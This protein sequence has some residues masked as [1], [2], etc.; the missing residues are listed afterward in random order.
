VTGTQFLHLG[1]FHATSSG[2]GY[3][4]FELYFQSVLINIALASKPMG[5][6]AHIHRLQPGCRSV[7]HDL[8]FPFSS[9]IVETPQICHF[10]SAIPDPASDY[11]PPCARLAFFQAALKEGARGGAAVVMP[12]LGGPCSTLCCDLSYR[13]LSASTRIS[14]FPALD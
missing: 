13:G 7:L 14:W 6:D 9:P 4:Y 5:S 8:L 1:R 3:L 10:V 11:H 12:W 2:R